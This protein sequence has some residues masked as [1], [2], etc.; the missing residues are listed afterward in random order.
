MKNRVLAFVRLLTISVALFF[1]LPALHAD[2]VSL[3]GLIERNQADFDQARRDKERA[4]DARAAR[5]E[6]RDRSNDV[7]YS[8]PSGSD[9]ETA[10]LGKYILAIRNDR[11]RN[12]MMGNC[13][14]LGSSKSSSELS[15]VCA[16]G[17]NACTALSDG[18]A[19]YHCKKCGATR[20]WLAVYSLGHVIQCF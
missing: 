9:A 1:N 3:G 4:D 20:R 10:C 19:S 5:R 16:N 18:N 14:S 15:Y 13:L 11:A 17:L 8:L 12:I 2:G 6:N 7:C